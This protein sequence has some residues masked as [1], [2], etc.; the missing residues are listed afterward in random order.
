MGYLD[1][2][3]QRI[4]IIP[5]GMWS[6]LPHWLSFDFIGK[7][8]RAPKLLQTR[9]P[10]ADALN[11]RHCGQ[12]QQSAVIKRR[13]R[14]A[15]SKALGTERRKHAKIKKKKAKQVA[16]AYSFKRKGK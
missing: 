4:I 10:P 11:R 6:F 5:P 8:R 12:S 16:A 3:E 14:L 2:L 1:F 15:E 7:N 13:E 9:L